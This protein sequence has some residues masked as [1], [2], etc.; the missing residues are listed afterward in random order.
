MTNKPTYSV[1][2]R[3]ITVDADPAD[4]HGIESIRIEGEKHL[5]FGQGMTCARIGSEIRT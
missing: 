4:W 2:E 3:K 1:M 5:W